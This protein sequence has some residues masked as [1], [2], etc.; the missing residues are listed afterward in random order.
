VAD[1]ICAVEGMFGEDFLKVLKLSR[2]AAHLKKRAV[3]AADSD[4]G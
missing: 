4:P 1:T 2:S 3:G